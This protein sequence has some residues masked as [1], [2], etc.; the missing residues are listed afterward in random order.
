[1]KLRLNDKE[2]V[3]NADN[4]S[5]EHLAIVINEEQDFDDV[6]AML[7]DNSNF[8]TVEILNDAGELLSRFYDMTNSAS[9]YRVEQIDGVPHVVLT[10][11]PKTDSDRIIDLES[12]IGT[13]EKMKEELNG[14]IDSLRTS[15][16]ELEAQNEFLTECLIEIGNVIY[17]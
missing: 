5:M 15:K 1:M 13:L 17:A 12:K 9:G 14:E 3:I 16:E 4:V 2:F 7:F 11:R 6:I 8:A 10:L